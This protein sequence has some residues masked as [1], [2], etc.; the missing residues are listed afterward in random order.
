MLL[1]TLSSI[2]DALPALGDRAISDIGSLK[3]KF[4]EYGGRL[5]SIVQQDKY[6]NSQAAIDNLVNIRYKRMFHYEFTDGDLKI[7]QSKL[8]E[9][10]DIIVGSSYMDDGFK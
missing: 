8:N 10:R 3:M 6:R 4:T 5:H 1:G 7:L 2:S 9:L